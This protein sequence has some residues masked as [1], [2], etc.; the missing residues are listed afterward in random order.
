MKAK[1]LVYFLSLQLIFISFAQ[2]APVCPSPKMTSA[3]TFT[4]LCR[5]V[6]DIICKDVPD[7]VRRSCDE[8][9]HTIIHSGMTA[10]EVYHFAKGCMKSV[11]TSF[12]KFFTEFL[13]DLCKAIWQLTKGAYESVSDP[14]GFF[15]TLKGYYESARSMAA[16]VYEAVKKDPGQFFAELWNKITDAVGPLVAS[17]DCLNP[18][19]KV[20][21]I[22]G[23]IGEWVMPPAVLAKVIV[24][25]TKAAKELYQLRL[26]TKLGEAKAAQ[27]IK[28]FE[29]APKLSLRQYQALFKMYKD[30]G[31]SIDDFRELYLSGKLKADIKPD[32][33]KPKTVEKK[34]AVAS[35]SASSA[36]G[37]GMDLFK[38]K[39][40]RELKL[41]PKANQEFMAHVEADLLKKNPDVLYFDVEN[42]VQ[43]KLND[44][45]FREKTAVDALNNSFFL[46]F[47]QKLREFPELMERLGGEYK[48]Y[49]S[50]RIRLQL[51]PGDDPEKY[52]KLL[53]ELYKKTNA[54]FFND[55][56][57]K[58]VRKD[59]PPRT[60][61]LADPATWFL[62][63]SGNNALEANMAAR[64]GRKNAGS[65]NHPP[66]LNSFKEHVATLSKEIDSIESTRKTLSGNTALLQS[67][68]LETADNG[69]IVPSKAMIGILRKVK[70]GDFETEEQFLAKIASKTKEMFGQDINTETARSLAG[71]FKQVDSLSPPLFSTE[72]VAINLEEAKKGIVSIDFAGIGVDNIYEQMKALTEVSA[73]GN[74]EK[75]LS[76][77]FSKMQ[78]G[79]NQVT[80]QMEEAKDVFR[81]AV[82]DIDGTE[83]KA[84][85]F[86]GDDGIFMP[87]N[88]NWKEEDKAKLVQS[89]ASSSDPSK[90]RVT[91]VSSTYADGK[92]IP[93][94][95]RSKRIVRAET[96]E[97]DIRS[98]IIG[99]EKISEAEAKK[100]I[101]AID[102]SP[103][104]KGGTFNL[105]LGGKKF[106]AEEIKTIE[107]AF[108][109][110]LNGEGEKFGRVIY[111][112]Q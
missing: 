8:K 40:A 99:A 89:L 9:D 66:K 84:P 27:A 83:K 95:E 5:N 93:T 70:P 43:K 90:F 94:A 81:K 72:R 13:P 58:Q 111:S 96:V 11:A 78:V 104:E 62:G 7:S 92:V 34:T 86:S 20:E 29:A 107:D 45:I 36:P 103:S 15:S 56:L 41:P 6:D 46:K 109:S 106:T 44:E 73:K 22:C 35:S 69:N 67:R 21:K 33:I 14:G 4:R 110:S 24:K 80:K 3:E 55:P 108:R 26:V 65:T 74:A 49:K 2:A 77:S 28:A 75:K 37:K 52:Q 16:D 87:G 57:L 10:G 1:L 91:F 38:A 82:S 71:Y 105:I 98:R 54:E 97:K 50:Y 112:A 39:Y 30:K 32:D 17:Y 48:D 53:A 68:I 47:N 101:T 25:G 23:I 31:Y 76:E 64:S 19:A 59:L 100:F 88:R 102:Y 12:A 63:G 79:V 18:Q 51:K 85:L 60:D 61:N 42:S